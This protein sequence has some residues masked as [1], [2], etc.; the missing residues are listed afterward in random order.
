MRFFYIEIRDNVSSEYVIVR[1]T[2]F[3]GSDQKIESSAG[4][5]GWTAD[6]SQE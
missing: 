5:I 6:K 2:I 4:G 1:L 3:V